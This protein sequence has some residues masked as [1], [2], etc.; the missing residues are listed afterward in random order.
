MKGYQNQILKPLTLNL[1]FIYKGLSSQ[2]KNFF[3]LI[4]HFSTINSLISIP[5][6]RAPP[7]IFS[8]ISSPTLSEVTGIALLGNPLPV[9]NG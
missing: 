2:D 6:C 8:R 7:C 4:V 3:V 9:K 1:I 5:V